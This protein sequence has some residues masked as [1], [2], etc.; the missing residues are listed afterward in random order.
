MPSSNQMATKTRIVLR[1]P[2][3]NFAAPAPASAPLN[4]LFMVFPWTSRPYACA[5]AASILIP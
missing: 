2:P 4:S 1:Q 3:P 5:E